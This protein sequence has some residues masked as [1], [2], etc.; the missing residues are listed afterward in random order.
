MH[1]Q[2]IKKHIENRTSKTISLAILFFLLISVK[3][4]GQTSLFFDDYNQTPVNPIVSSGQPNANYT[5]WTNVTPPTENG[6]TVLIEKY[7]ADDGVIEL[8]AADDRDTQTGNRTEVSAPLSIYN[9]PFNSTLNFNTK[10]LEWI[11]TLKQNRSSAGGSVGFNGSNTG[12]AV[13]LAADTSIWE[14][15]Q[16][17]AAKG[18]AVTFLKPNGSM[19]CV[20]LSRF[21]HGLSNYEVLVGNNTEDIFSEFKT[22]V[23]VK[24]TYSSSTNKWE[25]FFRD[26]H[27]STVKGDISD[28]NGLKL[29]GS[30]VDSTYTKIEMSHF[31]FA[32]NT[33]TP[34]VAGAKGNALYVD[35]FAVNAVDSIVQKFTI[36]TSNSS[37]GG[38]VFVEPELDTYSYGSQV[39]ISA[40]PDE[41]YIFEK[42]SGDVTS[43]LNSTSVIINADMNIIASFIP[44]P[45]EL[46]EKKKLI[47]YDEVLLEAVKEELAQNNSYFV[48]AFNSLISNASTE[49]NKEANPVTNKSQ[50][51]P[52]GNKNDYLSLAPYW[53]PDLTKS[54]SLPWIRKDGEVNPMTRG[55]NTDQTRLSDF[56][57]SLELLSFAYYF[58]D[59]TKYAIKTIDLLN[60]WLVNEVTKINPHANYAQGVPGSSTGRQ[61]G[62]I[63]FGGVD[64]IIAAMQILENK[65]ILP[66]S[67]KNGVDKWLSDWSIWLRTSSFGV[68]EGEMGNNHGTWYDYQVLGLLLYEGKMSD[69]TKLVSDFKIKRIVRQIN[70]D[71]SQ[72]Q[73]LERTKSVSYSTMNLWGMTKVA[74]MGQQA[75]INLK[76]YQSNDGRS[77]KKAYDFFRPYVLNPSTWLWEQITNGGKENALITLTKPLFSRASTIFREDL[78]PQNENTDEHLSYL[79][80]LVYPPRELILPSG[81]GVQKNK[82]D[83]LKVFPNPSTG[84]FNVKVQQ[85]I[86]YKVFTINGV[87]IT[88]G[89]AS[90]SFVLDLSNSN[91]S[92]LILQIELKDRVVISRIVK[93]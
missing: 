60:I 39:K 93:N 41:G 27:S 81:T 66:E 54:D 53:W 51:P 7:A 62:I 17:S 92:V 4:F 69:A 8:L 49:L 14:S 40:V 37:T 30:V 88:E 22:W 34:S 59:D 67:T 68:L 77:I 76:N 25:L 84:K 33:P 11:F 5:I 90:G 21:D 10:D 29:I 58:S 3:S 57:N 73:E 65:G 50:I 44:E 74:Q 46:V 38:L 28:I 63:E 85:Q 56:F 36:N 12:M 87:L 72:P 23:T 70:P 35:D 47:H 31:G 45:Q 83:D 19:Y 20:S 16:G 86:N 71:G 48:S 42:W 24:V 18:Y 89:R 26:E 82:F 1:K 79:E 91:N 61:I 32:L 13:I 15:Q 6:G 78:I 9:A 2:L 43:F 80:K 52:S 75:G 64:N 55:D